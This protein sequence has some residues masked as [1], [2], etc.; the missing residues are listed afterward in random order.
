MRCLISVPSSTN[1]CDYTGVSV[2][3]YL[4]NLKTFIHGEASAATRDKVVRNH[5][6]TEYGKY[7][8]DDKTSAC[9][10]VQLALAAVALREVS[11]AV[12]ARLDDNR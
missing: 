2:G 6:I 4:A 5:F 11:S 3:L 12:V 9:D 1:L 10:I 8:I 7:L